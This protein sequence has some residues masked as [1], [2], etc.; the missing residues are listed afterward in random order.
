[1]TGRLDQDEKLLSEFFI[2]KKSAL[3]Y[4]RKLL[5]RCSEAVWVAGRYSKLL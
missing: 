1:M 4:K 3:H 5:R 2:D